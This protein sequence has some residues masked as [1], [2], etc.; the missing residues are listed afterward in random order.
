MYHRNYVVR[1]LSFMGIAAVTLTGCLSERSEEPADERHVDVIIEEVDIS[2]T[3]DGNEA[4]LGARV[5]D[6]AIVYMSAGSSS[7]PATI[8]AVS[9]EGKDISLHVKQYP[10]DAICTMDYVPIMQRITREDRDPF[11]ADAVVEVENPNRFQ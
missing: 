8:E 7:C 4:D 10:A 1:A 11:P 5:E 9:Q 2:E 3:W 6:G